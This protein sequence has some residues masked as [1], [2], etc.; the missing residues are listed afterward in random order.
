MRKLWRIVSLAITPLC[1]AV[2]LCE[3]DSLAQVEPGHDHEAD[4]AGEHLDAQPIKNVWGWGYRSLNA[5]GGEW[6]E[7]QHHMPPPFSMQVL[8]FVVFAVL[9]YRMGG[10]A[11]IK[12]TRE[13]HDTIAK[14]LSEGTRLRDEAKARL[15]EYETK[16]AALQG[17]I[18]RLVANIRAEAETEKKRIIAEAEQ[19]ADRMRRD[20][21]QQIQAEIARV[22][23]V[24]EREAVEAAI[25]IAERILKE[26]TT[27]ADQRLLADR[28]V[29][30]L[31]DATARRRT[32]T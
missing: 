25:T 11:L 6:H 19:R 13:R 2:L 7:G 14:A 29:K 22:R 10:P 3:P 5:E 8:N 15:A 32:G 17:E 26:K 4:E 16:L 21:E 28:F 27:E 1:V 9:M 31:S 30:G 18:E 20:A 24:L 12:S 23:I